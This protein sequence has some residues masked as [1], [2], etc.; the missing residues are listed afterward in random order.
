M[1]KQ[2]YSLEFKKAAVEK[3]LIRGSRRV[4]AI[5]E[6]VG[7]PYSTLYQ[8]KNDFAKVGGMKK[9]SRPEDRSAAEKLKILI[10]YEATPVEGRGELLRRLGV[11]REH[12]EAWT[13]QV[14]KALRFGAIG[15]HVARSERAE[16]RRKIK[17]LERDVRRKDRALAETTAL[18]VLK[19]KADLI[20]GIKETE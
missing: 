14:H 3:F 9:S 7:V 17:E 10:E 4:A 2:R 12:V 15:K 6:E 8:W 20:W 13:E 18:L 11:H 1:E 19:K 5:V 16:D